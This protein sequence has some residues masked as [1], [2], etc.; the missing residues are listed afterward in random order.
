MDLP[1][2]AALDISGIRYENSAL[3]A[4]KLPVAALNTSDTPGEIDNFYEIGSG[5][6]RAPVCMRPKKGTQ[7]N[8]QP[9][10]LV[11]LGYFT[12]WTLVQGTSTP[13]IRKNSRR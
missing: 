11:G 2:A 13:S 12:S 1:H 8:T 3:L 10:G 6:R 5:Y 9:P 7:A 4:L